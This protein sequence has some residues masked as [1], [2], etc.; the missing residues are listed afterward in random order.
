MN[1]LLMALC[2]AMTVLGCAIVL[3]SAV[4]GAFC[5]KASGRR[6]DVVAGI[7]PLLAGLG[8]LYVAYR[9]WEAR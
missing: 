8:A 5:A 9:I 4:M 3:G 2:V 7:P 6:L 1:I